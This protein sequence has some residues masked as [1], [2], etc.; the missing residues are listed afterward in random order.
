MLALQSFEHVR[1]WLTKVLELVYA[2]DYCGLDLRHSAF[3]WH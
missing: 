1:T 2:R 3:L